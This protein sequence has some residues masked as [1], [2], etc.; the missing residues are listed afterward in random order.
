MT[1]PTTNNT[2]PKTRSKTLGCVPHDSYTAHTSGLK[3]I[4]TM[5]PNERPTMRKNAPFRHFAKIVVSS[6]EK[7]TSPRRNPTARQAY[8]ANTAGSGSML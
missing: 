5:E 8:T 3:N 1:T 4:V 6:L 2:S 7:V